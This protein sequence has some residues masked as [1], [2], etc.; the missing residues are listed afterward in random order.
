MNKFL[1]FPVFASWKLLRS[2]KENNVY[3]DS[4]VMIIGSTSLYE[5]YD[6]V[7]L[8]VNASDPQ[9]EGYAYSEELEIIE[10]LSPQPSYEE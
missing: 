5:L 1:K 9:V 3:R 7:I 4:V 10:T 2:I 8:Y 6:Y